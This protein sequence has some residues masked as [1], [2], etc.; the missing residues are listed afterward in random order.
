M[1][2]TKKELRNDL[3]SD[4]TQRK[5]VKDAVNEMVDSMLK[6][7]SEKEYIKSTIEVLKQDL[8][9]DPKYIRK[10]AKLRFDSQYGEGKVK[11]D[12][13]HSSQIISDSEILFS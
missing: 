5:R 6:Q 7:Q 13:E 12:L 9:L 4:P 2:R 3:P 11:I 1:A 10:L 8:E